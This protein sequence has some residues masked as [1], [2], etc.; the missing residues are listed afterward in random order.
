MFITMT[1]IFCVNKTW[2]VHRRKDFTYFFQRYDKVLIFQDAY[3]KKKMCVR[4]PQDFGDVLEMLCQNGKYI[5]L[6]D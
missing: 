3:T 4:S 1:L 6:L 5:A 2:I